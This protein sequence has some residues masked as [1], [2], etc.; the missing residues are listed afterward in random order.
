MLREALV[1]SSRTDGFAVSAYSFAARVAVLLQHRESYLPALI[2]LLRYIHPRAPLSEEHLAEFA[3]YYVLHLACVL[4]DF[5]EAYL[6]RREFRAGLE[7]HGKSA[8]PEN[9][10]RTVPTS[11]VSTTTTSPSSSW[12]TVDAIL[13]SLVRNDY[14]AW[15][16]IRCRMATNLHIR[17]LMD[18]GEH[19][20]C[21]RAVACLSKAYFEVQTVWLEDLVGMTWVD[22]TRTYNVAAAAGVE[23]AEVEAGA[24]GWEVTEDGQKVVV[25]RRK[26]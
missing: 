15:S 5:N 3:G 13:C 4:G 16:R 25:R 17:R 19:A 7:A 20:M 9:V 26:K 1:A 6:I 18:M 8:K 2:R 11:T 22:F 24:G 23:G 14:W 10:D 21:A 12:A